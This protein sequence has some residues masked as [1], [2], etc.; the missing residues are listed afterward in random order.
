MSINT[1]IRERRRMLGLTQEQ[2]ADYL[3]VSAPAVNKWEKGLSYPDTGLLAPLARLLKTDMNE[4]FE[5]RQKLTPQEVG[6]FTNEITELAQ[7][8]GIRA[9]FLRA[10]EKLREYPDSDLLLYSV[11][12]VLAGSLLLVDLEEGEREDYE[13]KIRGWYEQVAE[14]GAGDIREKAAYMLAGQYL[15]EG[16]TEKAEEMLALLPE[17]GGPNKNF[18][19]STVLYQKGDT[20]EAVRILTRN[21]LSAATEVQSLMLKLI[22]LELD[23]GQQ[24]RAI[25]MAQASR[26]LAE[27]LELWE[28][29]RYVGPMQVAVTLKEERQSLE[30]I[31]A[32]LASIQKPWKF[33]EEG[34][35]G[36]LKK[37]TK[38]CEWRQLMN[39][40]LSEFEKAPQYEFLRENQEFW[41]ILRRYQTQN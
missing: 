36:S 10:Q 32:L 30:L 28:Y 38:P 25:R 16:N 34:L 5:F 3:G 39:P 15:R 21:L 22:D 9:A 7:Q 18:L 41:E 24:D 8:K 13:R 23:R 29:N 27:D 4:L 2:V 6:H 20:E 31:S 40:L 37:E 17:P 14:K 12:A 1:I 11:A 33:E 19:W 35:Y 26:K